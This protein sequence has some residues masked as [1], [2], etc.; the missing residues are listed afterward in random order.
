MAPQVKR[1]VILL[2]LLIAPACGALL[3]PDGPLAWYVL[4]AALVAVLLWVMQRGRPLPERV[5]FWLGMLIH[6][7]AAGYGM[8]TESGAV[9]AAGLWLLLVAF[10][11]AAEA[12]SRGE[13][14]Q[15]P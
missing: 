2:G 6:I 9:S 14:W 8:A 5:V 13:A 11:V 3:L 1:S 12:A 10:A 7:M 15:N 4:D